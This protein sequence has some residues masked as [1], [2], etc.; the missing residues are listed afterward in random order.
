[1][2]F[3]R[4]GAAGEG[5]VA[6]DSAQSAEWAFFLLKDLSARKRAAQPFLTTWRPR[7]SAG[8]G[9]YRSFILRPRHD[10]GIQKLIPPRIGASYRRVIQ[11]QA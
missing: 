11:F 4:Q 3:Q 2:R 9:T 5:L 8:D 7:P 1:V 6:K 10:F